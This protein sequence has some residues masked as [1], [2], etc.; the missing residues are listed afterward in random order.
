MAG[1]HLRLYG[2][3]SMQA[4]QWMRW[5]DGIFNLTEVSFTKLQELVMA[6]EAWCAA[7]HGVAKSWT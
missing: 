2:H 1:W 4:Q 3:K 5:L 6:R 7:V